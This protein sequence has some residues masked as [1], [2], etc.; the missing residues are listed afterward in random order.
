MFSWFPVVCYVMHNLLQCEDIEIEGCVFVFMILCELLMFHLISF[1]QL[2]GMLNPG[3][4]CFV[5]W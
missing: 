2:F 5:L 4:L 1:N 3:T